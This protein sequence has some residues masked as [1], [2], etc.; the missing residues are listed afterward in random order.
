MALLLAL[1]GAGC[2]PGRS[3]EPAAGAVS[4]HGGLHTLTVPLPGQVV[5]PDNHI[6]V[7]LPDGYCRHP[8]WAYPV[9]YLLHGAGDTYRS[10]ADRTDL[11]TWAPKLPVAI[12]LPDAGHGATATWYSDW[13]TGAYQEE[14]YLTS[15]LPSFVGR[16]FRVLARRRAVAGNSMGGFGA[17]SLAARHPGMFEAAASFSGAVDTLYDAPLSGSIFA[18][19]NA[20][21]GTPD[22]RI[23]GDQTR[24]RATWAAHDPTLLAARL[25]GVRLFI[26][27][28]TGAR[29]GREGDVSNDPGAY[30]EEAG[31][32]LMNESLI[33]AL[34][35]AGIPYQADLY[36]GGYH[37]WP[38]WSAD[39]HRVLPR[40]SAVLGPARTASGKLAAWDPPPSSS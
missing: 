26:A 12:V 18:R 28:G 32:H 19:L 29:G 21:D 34:D 40:I 7:L 25:R 14:S 35:R 9:L 27:S 10:W 8:T 15:V 17:L 5:V 36:P 38:Y 4:C 33:G 39:L 22:A 13:A 6:E 23:W 37:G 24:D 20:V 1:A 3:P 16:H 11:V 2:H 30:A 31:I